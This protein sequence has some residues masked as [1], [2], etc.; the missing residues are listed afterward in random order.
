MAEPARHFRF[1]RLAAR[2]TL[3]TKVV[4]VL[5][6][7]AL[8]ALVL[9]FAGVRAQL[10]DATR[11]SAVRDQLTVVRAAV[12]L[13]E[14]VGRELDD[15]GRADPTALRR[16]V[17]VARPPAAAVRALDDALGRLATERARRS[18]DPAGYLRVI[19]A[20]SDI[21]PAVVS[22]AGDQGLDDTADDLRQLMRLRGAVDAEPAV[23]ADVLAD[24][25]GVDAGPAALDRTVTGRTD[26][27]AAA[28]ED[29]ARTARTDALR[30]AATVFGAL[31]AAFALALAV[32]RA[33]LTPVRG[34]RAAALAAAHERLPDVVARVRAGTDVG[35]HPVRPA[36]TDEELGQL[37]TAFDD[38]A[39]QAV[40]LA[41]EQ[42]ELRRQVS[43]MFMT[44]SRRSQSLV[45]RQLDLI[46]GLE[47]DEEDPRR[48]DGLFRL[49]HLATRLRRNGENLQVLAGG[50]PARRDNGVHGAVT[51]AEL[52][53][54]ATSEVNDYRRIALGHAPNGS[55]R[56]TAAA[57]VAHILAELLEN[58]AR[59][60]PPDRQVVL[61]ADR[62]T[63]G[64]LL[65]EVADTG[66]GMAADDLD[67]TNARLSDQGAEGAVGPETTRRMGLF[68]VSRL[69]ARHGITVRLR[70][71]HDAEDE[72]GTTASVHVPGGLVVADGVVPVNL[73]SFVDLPAAAGPVDDLPASNWFSPTADGEDW[74][75]P[76]DESWAAA[77]AVPVPVATTAVGLPMRE[78]SG[79]VSPAGGSEPAERT[80]RDPDSVRSNLSRHNRGVRAA[81]DGL[82]D[83]REGS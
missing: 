26:A 77:A 68:V 44:L 22:A 27:L 36:H 19:A 64:G 15:E 1:R 75:T 6:A 50:V 21:V 31:L 49:D 73:M 29:L 39:R 58:A 17:D 43:E 69:A 79:W 45:E 83:T 28:V 48:L 67:A 4:V 13:A 71:T 46:E 24:L 16:A 3:R 56:A 60:S 63:D 2:W 74:H 38:M 41:A 59:F 82:A 54:A 25:L 35:W 80:V 61:A 10:D 81:R 57:D 14:R 23:D 8:V 33:A 12:V 30:V 20:L 78:P 51:V 5:L 72:P 37:A 7:P 65:L 55:I 70:P 11:L 47:A 9:G 34:L 76:A 66:L 53:R 40:A 52:M 32:A 62:T 42:A 18:A